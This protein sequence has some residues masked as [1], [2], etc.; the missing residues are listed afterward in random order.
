MASSKVRRCKRIAV[1]WAHGPAPAPAE[2]GLNRPLTAILRGSAT[3]HARLA[4]SGSAWAVRAGS[5]APQS[6]RSRL[7]SRQAQDLGSTKLVSSPAVSKSFVP[8]WQAAGFAL[9]PDVSS[10]GLIRSLIPGE[11][12]SEPAEEGSLVFAILRLLF[13]LHNRSSFSSCAE[14]HR[15]CGDPHPPKVD[16]QS[17]HLA[18]ARTASIFEAGAVEDLEWHNQVQIAVGADHQSVRFTV[19]GHRLAPAA[20]HAQMPMARRNSPVLIL[21]RHRSPHFYPEARVLCFPEKSTA[22]KAAAPSGNTSPPIRV[23]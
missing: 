12:L 22:A 18:P 14:P 8:P 15:P 9:L 6:A 20:A 1:A 11:V 3:L 4:G 23:A 10:A 5:H 2:D 16:R 13:R 7:S 17:L 21:F 19:P